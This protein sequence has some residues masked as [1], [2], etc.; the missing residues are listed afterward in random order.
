MV[1]KRW[2]LSS[3]YWPIASYNRR[4]IQSHLVQILDTFRS[5][6]QHSIR[7][8]S[9]RLND[10]SNRNRK[11]KGKDSYRKPKSLKKKKEKNNCDMTTI[12]TSESL[13]KDSRKKKAKNVLFYLARVGH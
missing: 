7:L 1:H 9:V 10:E 4:E 11:K 8:G 3:D 12:C 6:K 5:K 2:K 13:I